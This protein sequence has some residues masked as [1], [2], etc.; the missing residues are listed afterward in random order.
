MTGG[1]RKPKSTNSL[2]RTFFNYVDQILAF[3]DLLPLRTLTLS[4]LTRKRH[5]WTTYPPPLVKVVK[6]CPPNVLLWRLRT[7]FAASSARFILIGFDT[8]ILIE[9]LRASN[10]GNN[11]ENAKLGTSKKHNKH[12]WVVFVAYFT[13]KYLSRLAKGQIISKANC[14]VMNS[15]KKTNQW[16]SF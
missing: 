6:E 16:I 5:F 7:I 10:R 14:Q 4:T 13:V 3:F 1:S 2:G 8:H 9:E 15:S 12:N 11:C